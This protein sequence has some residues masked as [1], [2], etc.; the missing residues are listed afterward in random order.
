M[1]QR[2]AVLL[3][4]LEIRRVTLLGFNH[5]P[6][7]ATVQYFRMQCSSA[8]AVWTISP[9]RRFRPHNARRRWPEM[10]NRYTSGPTVLARFRP[11][12]SR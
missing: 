2:L 11:L 5:R 3:A 6:D 10:A 7:R 1:A 12:P 8:A 9:W 4:P